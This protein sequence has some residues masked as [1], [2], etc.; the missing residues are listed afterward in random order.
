MTE[1][2]K[3]EINDFTVKELIV[4]IKEWFNFI[5]SKWMIILFIGLVGGIVGYIYSSRK[6]ITYTAKLTFIIEDAK[7]GSGGLGGLASLA[8]QFGVDVGGGT[9]GGIFSGDNILLYFKSPSLAKEVLLSYYDS[10]KKNTL[11]DEYV[12]VHH[13][14]KVW[15]K[16]KNIG[17]FRFDSLSSSVEYNRTKDSLLQK[18]TENIISN[19]FKVIRPDKKASFI[20]VSVTMQEE[21]LAKVYCERIVKR[22]VDRYINTKIQ[23]QS[24]T[25]DKLQFRV[26]SIAALLSQKTLSSAFLQNNSNTMD[27]NP[28]YRTGSNVALETTIRDKTLLSTIFASVS[29]NLEMA[30][31]TLSQETPVIQIIDSPVLPLKKEKISNLKTAFLFSFGFSFAFTLL[32]VIKRLYSILTDS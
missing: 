19:E 12:H 29:Q 30:K 20:E 7:N 27:I 10:S 31:F 15:E 8:G 23:R 3:N 13:L 5:L 14:D 6:P 26:D 25:V 16:N 17:R 18:I 1:I 11:V 28:L 2:I 21:N 22:V 24:A 4:K 9:G 32:I